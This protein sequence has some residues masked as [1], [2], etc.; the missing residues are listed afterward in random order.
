MVSKSTTVPDAD[1]LTGVGVPVGDAVGV[2][3]ALG[4]GDAPTGVAVAIGVAVLTGAGVDVGIEVGVT[5][6]GGG[7][8]LP[9]LLQAAREALVIKSARRTIFVL[10]MIACT[11]VMCGF[12][13]M[14]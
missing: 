7:L 8:P 12:W 3:V 4:V 14:R 13:L 1:A 11:F 10:N 9:P 2:A 5:G 6:I